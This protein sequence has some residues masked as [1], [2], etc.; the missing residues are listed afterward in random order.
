MRGRAVRRSLVVT[1]MGAGLA[2]GAPAV[3]QAPEYGTMIVKHGKQSV[4]ATLGTNCQPTATGGQECADAKYPLAT[5][6]RVTLT[7]GKEVKLLLKASAGYVRWRAARVTSA[8]EEVLLTYGEANVVSKTKRQWRLTVPKD[9]RKSATILGFD[10][11]YPS[12]YASFEVGA[13]VR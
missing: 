11:V 4:Q 1:V 12:A 5:T 10:V 9:L 6:G 13:K 3:A 8:G 7:R 2:A